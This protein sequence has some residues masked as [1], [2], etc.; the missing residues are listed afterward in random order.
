MST[1]CKYIVII[2]KKII[3]FETLHMW[4]PY[5][6][7]GSRRLTLREPLWLSW[8]ETFHMHCTCNNHG[9]NQIMVVRYNF[10]DVR[11]K[12]AAIIM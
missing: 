5:Q 11:S 4:P 7:S 9:E 12:D 3:Y 6:K 1:S 8:L 2:F 10:C